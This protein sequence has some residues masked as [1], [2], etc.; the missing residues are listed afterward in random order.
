MNF[1]WL[2]DEKIQCIMRLFEARVVGGAVRN[3]LLGLEY[4][5]IDL[6]TILTVE[7]MQVICKQNKLHCILT[8]VEHGTITVMYKSECF[9]IT[10]LRRD[11]E[12]DGRHA[13]VEFTDSWEEDAKRRDFTFNALYLDETGR[14]Y[15]YFDGISD[16]KQGVVRFIGDPYQ[17]IQEDYL[18]IMR[19]FRF[20]TYYGKEI[21]E[22]SLKACYDCI[23]GLKRVSKERIW[24][25]LYKIA[26]FDTMILG[27]CWNARELYDDLR[28]W[29]IDA[30]NIRYERIVHLQRVFDLM[31]LILKGINW[32]I[33][34]NVSYLSL[35]PFTRLALFDGDWS[36]KSLSNKQLKFLVSL[37]AMQL[38]SKIDWM[39]CRYF[40]DYEWFKSKVEYEIVCGLKNEGGDEIDAMID[41]VMNVEHVFEMRLQEKGL[42]QFPVNGYD[43]LQ[44]G[45]KGTEIGVAMNRL[46]DKWFESDMKM[47][48]EELLDDGSGFE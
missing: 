5:E 15:D 30:V 11:V 37:R 13:K 9:E 46:Y 35:H 43:L 44:M 27:Y 36:D 21:D 24:S 45:L 17:R 29:C 4:K 3:S 6:A 26:Q 10:T 18:R 8:G 28:K 38:N 40:Q 23:D 2:K 16:L 7:Q 39:R 47:S 14:I 12:T 33:P 34:T 25:E 48:K 19:F 1:T 20:Y 32:P 31:T 42:V 22:C 41:V